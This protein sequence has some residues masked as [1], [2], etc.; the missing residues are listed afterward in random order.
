MTIFTAIFSNYDE[1]KHP[2][3]ITEGWHYILYTDLDIV[4]NFWEIRKVELINND[5]ILTARYY[6]IM[7][8][9]HIE[10]DFSIWIDGS[11]TIGCDLDKFVVGNF[12]SPMTV[13]K[14]P[15]RNCIYREADICIQQKRGDR[16]EI[17]RQIEAYR[18][19]VPKNAGLIQSGILMRE[20]TRYTIEFCTAW[21]NQVLTFSTRDQISF[22]Y[23][24]EFLMV[25]PHVIRFNYQTSKEFIFKKHDQSHRGIELHHT[26]KG[27]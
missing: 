4:S 3:V 15:L 11:F 12:K 20:K 6:K 10:D 8:H 22:T 24:A 17:E 2:L 19:K 23:C 18:G 14:H 26:E 7:F 5:P 1:L 9:E 25:W 13:V 16:K 21:W 27:V